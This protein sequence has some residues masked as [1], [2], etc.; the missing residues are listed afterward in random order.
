[1]PPP[2]YLPSARSIVPGA[3]IPSRA[4]ALDDPLCVLAELASMGAAATAVTFAIRP[5]LFGPSWYGRAGLAAF[6]AIAAWLTLVCLLRQ[7]RRAEEQTALRETIGRQRGMLEEIGATN[8]IME[9]LQVCQSLTEANRVICGALPKLLREVAGAFYLSRGPDSALELQVSWAGFTPAQSVPPQDCWALRRGRSYLFE[10]ERHSVACQHTGTVQ[11]ASLCIPLVSDGH[12]FALLHVQ[13]GS[14]EPLSPDVQR[15]ASALC[16]ALSLAV[17]NLRLQETLRTGS[18]RDPLTDLYNRRHLELSLQR[19]LARA[20][21]H[22]HPVS[23]VMLDVDHF[24]AFNDAHGHDVGDAVLREVAHTLR[25][26]TRGEDIAC[27]YGGEEF[28]LALPSCTLDD[29]YAKA[30]A[31][32]EAI[33]QLRLFS[34]GAALP[35]VTASFGICCYPVDGERMDELITCAD[36]ALYQAKASGRNRI[37]ANS[38]PG[39]VVLF[40]ERVHAAC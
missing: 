27:R 28:L 2:R 7:A 4:W 6:V 20:Q 35:R 16:E 15:F 14:C 30:E 8:A 39:D 19:E 26:H 21:R 18:E 24:K 3:S 23:F 5:G 40:D 22:G 9:L 11:R 31:I 36:T 29:A 25:R 10:P 12:A 1:M 33:A 34:R 38:P 13:S 17:G 32:R 37:I